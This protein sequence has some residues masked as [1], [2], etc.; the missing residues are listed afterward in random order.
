MPPEAEYQKVEVTALRQVLQGPLDEAREPPRG[1][2]P[3]TRHERDLVVGEA[4]MAAQGFGGGLGVLPG[5]VQLPQQVVLID[6]D[7]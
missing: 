1:R 7:K 6:A 4:A 2:L 5:I 3:T